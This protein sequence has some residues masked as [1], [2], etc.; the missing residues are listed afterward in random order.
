[1]ADPTFQTLTLIVP[2]LAI[3]YFLLW[4]PQQQRA[5]ELRK[6]IEGLRRG[7]TVVIGGIVGR[8]VKAPGAEDAEVLVEIADNVQVKVLK[9]ALND[10]RPKAQSAEEKN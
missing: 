1:M 6:Q 7:D 10:V 4:R 9:A 3:F 8:V 5:K 2:M